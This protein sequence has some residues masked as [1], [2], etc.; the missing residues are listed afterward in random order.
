M[1]DRTTHQNRPERPETLGITRDTQP[2]TY[3]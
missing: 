2:V 1:T 3:G